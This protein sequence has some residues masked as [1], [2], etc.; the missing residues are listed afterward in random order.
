MIKDRPGFLGSFLS[1][2]FC[3]IS[4]LSFSIVYCSIFKMTVHDLAL[5]PLKIL[6]GV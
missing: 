4:S 1:F 2:D 5:C 6:R 3:L